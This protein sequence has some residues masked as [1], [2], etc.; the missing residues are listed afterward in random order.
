MKTEP[1]YKKGDVIILDQAEYEVLDYGTIEWD[2]KAWK[3]S[4]SLWDNDGYGRIEMRSYVDKYG[5]D[6]QGN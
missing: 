2:G 4:Y 6:E 1:K 3:D 5:K